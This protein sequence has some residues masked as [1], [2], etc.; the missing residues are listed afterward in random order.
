M[1][2]SMGDDY[3]VQTRIISRQ[4]GT[5][6]RLVDSVAGV[7]GIAAGRCFSLR[8]LGAGAAQTS[9]TLIFGPRFTGCFASKR[10]L[11]HEFPVARF[12]ERKSDTQRRFEAKQPVKRGPK[13]SVPDV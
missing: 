12:T 9:G 7:S 13:M 8:Q 1:R 3:F 10:Q 11:G 5:K 6:K 2:W 4:H